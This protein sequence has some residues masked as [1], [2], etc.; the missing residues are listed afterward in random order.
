MKDTCST[1]VFFQAAAAFSGYCTFLGVM[2][3][4]GIAIVD[5]H[6]V[7]EIVKNSEEQKIYSFVVVENT[8]ACIGYKRI[9]VQ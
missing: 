4:K 6:S 9:I 1:C 5:A 2:I 3:D 8:F 7:L